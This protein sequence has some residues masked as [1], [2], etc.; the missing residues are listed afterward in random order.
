MFPCGEKGVSLT[1]H[2]T[3]PIGYEGYADCDGSFM[4]DKLIKTVG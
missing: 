4:V 3:F 1:R 2:I